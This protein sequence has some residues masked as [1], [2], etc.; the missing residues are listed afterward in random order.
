MNIISKS[1]CHGKNVSERVRKLVGSFDGNKNFKCDEY[2]EKIDYLWEKFSWEAVNLDK[3]DA[4][5][6]AIKSCVDFS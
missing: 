4:T 6:N 1:M 5:T 2:V 3:F